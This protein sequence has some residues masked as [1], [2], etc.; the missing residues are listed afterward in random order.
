MSD[1]NVV[2]DE[3]GRRGRNRIQYS[4]DEAPFPLLW[5]V[6]GL[7]Q[8]LLC[9]A[10]II[11]APIFIATQLGVSDQPEIRRQLLSI[12]LFTCGVATILQNLIGCRLPIIQGANTSFI[13]PMA[14]IFSLAKW[15][16]ESLLKEIPVVN[17]TATDEPWKMRMREIQGNLMLASTTQFVL[18]A[19]GL[20]GFFLKFIGP[21]TVA[22]TITVIGL[23]IG[24][25]AIPL[26]AQ[27]WG[28]AF[29]SLALMIIFALFMTNIRL[30]LP[31]YSSRDGCHASRTPIFQLLPVLI[32]VGLAW[33][34]S[35]VLT[36]TDVL[37]SNSTQPGHMARTDVR[38]SALYDSP[39]FYF[40]LPF[41]FGMPTVSAAGYVGML[42]ATIA[43]TIESTG[44]YFAAARVAEVTPPPPHAVNRGIAM[45]GFSS[46]IG[47]MIGGLCASTSYSENIGAIAVTKV[48]SRKV[49]VVAGILLVLAGVIGKIGAVFTIIPD[50]IIGGVNLI[51]LGMVTAV[52]VSTLQF[53]DL[54]STR[55]LMIIGTS[56][57]LGLKIPDWMASNSQAINTGSADFDQVLTVLLSTPMF[58]AGFT[59]CFLDNLVPGT[60]EERGIEKWRQNME[61]V[62]CNLHNRRTYIRVSLYHSIHQKSQMLWL[63]PNVTHL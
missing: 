3:A 49:F 10:G 62:W 33:F 40:P 42:A 19:T 37:P 53:I 13:A 34:L 63:L 60:E 23:Y 45:E 51:T 56:T 30:P 15:S 58:V 38:I 25:F 43:S 12:G 7:Q 35:F 28:I 16:D 59:G 4:V 31:T 54:R 47:G 9:V 36:V 41:Q 11:S 61:G 29:L 21:L 52:G 55:N 22:P 6:L 2:E 46:T 18:G 20:I 27:H 5:P 26:C 24:Q 50:P 17:G 32:S 1:N 8:S 48:A 44:D 14:A 39:W 57:M